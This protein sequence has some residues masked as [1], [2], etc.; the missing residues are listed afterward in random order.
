MLK[1]RLQVR[2]CDIQK[3]VLITGASSGMGRISCEFLADQDYIVFAGTRDISKFD[4]NTL[5]NIIPIELDI[6]SQNSIDEAV[7]IILDNCKLR[8]T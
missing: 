5:K 8:K 4:S 3:I 6:T 1:K 2:R 7:Q